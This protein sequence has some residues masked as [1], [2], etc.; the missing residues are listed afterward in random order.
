MYKYKIAY[1]ILLKRLHIYLHSSFGFGQGVK[2]F[3]NQLLY[4]DHSED[5]VLG[6]FSYKIHI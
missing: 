6:D 4:Q 5:F 2:I 1:M 3:Q